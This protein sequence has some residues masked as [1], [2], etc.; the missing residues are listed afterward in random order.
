MTPEPGRGDRSFRVDETDEGT[1]LDHFLTARCPDLSRSQ[2][3]RAVEAEG[4]RVDGRTRP[5]RFRLRTGQRVDFTPPPPPQ[6]AAEPEDIPLEV[7]HQD[8]DILVIDKP[9][10]MVVHPAPGHRTG[11]LVNALLHHF[12]ALPGGDD[13]RAGLVHRLDKD[14]SGLLV[15]ALTETS[16]RALQSQLRDRTLGRT[17]RTLSWGRWAEDAGT[18]TGALGR[19]PT[20]RQRMAVLEAGGK[21]A[22][23]RYEV[24]EDFGFVQH[25]E[26]GLET[27]RTHQ[28]RVHFAHH[29][30]PVVGDRTYGDDARVK[31]VHPLDRPAALDLVAAAG[32]QLLHARALRLTHPRTGETMRFA[33]PPPDDFRRAL[34]VLRAA[35]PSA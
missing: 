20:Q 27:G 31:G 21:P 1:R 12:D 35:A 3:Q 14:T 4:A 6:T 17:Y 19:H 32:R 25:C 7:V 29:H 10:G 34:E 22:V 5:S 16:L 26:V 30:H 13:L 11:T 15:V 23:T 2:V 24:R 8:A 28:I 33:A 9:A 18:L